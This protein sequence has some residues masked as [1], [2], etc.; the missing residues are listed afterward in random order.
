MKAVNMKNATWVVNGC[1]ASFESGNPGFGIQRE[2]GLFISRDG[3]TPSVWRTKK[4][5]DQ[6]APY[7]DTFTA[8][9]WVQVN[10]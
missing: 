10:L 7:A 5:A 9:T 4:I 8:H 1:K 6:L 2:D 3:S